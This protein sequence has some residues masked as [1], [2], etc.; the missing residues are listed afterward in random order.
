MGLLF[1]DKD[2]RIVAQAIEGVAP[3]SI[4]QRALLIVRAANEIG[5]TPA[6]L[7][8]AAEIWTNDDISAYLASH[9]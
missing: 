3:N 2:V 8:A 7:V 4:K 5:V 9:V 1:D 6:D